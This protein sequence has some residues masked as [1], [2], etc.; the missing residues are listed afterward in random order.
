MTHFS[1]FSAPAVVSGHFFYS[2]SSTVGI[3]LNNQMILYKQSLATV[4]R[5]NA[6]LM[7]TDLC[8]NQAQGGRP[9]LR[10]TGRRDK[11]QSNTPGI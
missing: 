3:V 2:I 1:F 7:G 6:C 4:G 9:L 10:L 5:K 11:L 8:Q